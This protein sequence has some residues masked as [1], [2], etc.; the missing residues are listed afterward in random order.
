M[1]ES[2]TVDM[3]PGFLKVVKKLGFREEK[4]QN[5][6][7]KERYFIKESWRLYVYPEMGFWLLENEVD[8]ELEADGDFIN[9]DLLEYMIEDVDIGW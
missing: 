3:F 1:L 4:S 9:T 8:S 6:A 7:V 5:K 2:E